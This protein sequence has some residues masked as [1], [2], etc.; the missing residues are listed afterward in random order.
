[1]QRKDVVDGNA[2][3]LQKNKVTDDNGSFNGWQGNSKR[4]I[5]KKK[6]KEETAGVAGKRTFVVTCRT[7]EGYE[8]MGCVIS[9]ERTQR[10]R[11]HQENRGV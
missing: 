4:R 10:K 1:M 11:K 2:H 3:S 9:S 6:V 5:R 7:G 8:G